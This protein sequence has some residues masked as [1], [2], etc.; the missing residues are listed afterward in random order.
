LL[1]CSLLMKFYFFTF[2][3]LTF[4]L[5]LPAQDTTVLKQQA[6]RFAEASFK[7]DHQ[8]VIELTYPALIEL[9]GGPV[10]LQKL[11]TDKIEA[12]R[13]RGVKKFSGEVGSP[14]KF[15]KAGTQ[16]HC[17]IPESIVLKVT[18]GHYTSRSYLLAVSNDKGKSWTFLDVGNMPADILHR[19]LP[20]YNNNLVIPS[21]S[22]PV[23]FAD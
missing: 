11:I 6:R 3:L 1:V 22:Q 23:Y 20:D 12:L 13:K 16:I 2:I 9:S 15:F 19:L 5:T 17:L 21:P 7:N 4:A 18:G 14:G 8:T 10:M